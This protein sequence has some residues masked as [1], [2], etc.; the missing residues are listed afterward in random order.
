M[1]II[2]FTKENPTSYPSTDTPTMR[3]FDREIDNCKKTC[4][5]LRKDFDIRFECVPTEGMSEEYIAKLYTDLLSTPKAEKNVTLD[6][7][8]TNLNQ[9]TLTIEIPSERNITNNYTMKVSLKDIPI[10]LFFIN[11]YALLYFEFPSKE[12]V[13]EV[14]EHEAC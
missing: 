14:V 7:K 12:N 9:G 2:D 1:K 3:I 11:G 13:C 5:D 8:E 10:S 6:V 4:E